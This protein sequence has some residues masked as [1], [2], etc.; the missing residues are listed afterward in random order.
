MTID[1]AFDFW[2]DAG[3]KDPDAYSPTLRHCHRLL[4][5]KRLP[6]GESLDLSDSTPGVY[7]HHRSG[8]GEFFLSRDSVM[9][10]FTKWPALK[11]ITDQFPEPE[12]HRYGIDF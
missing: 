5:S 2:T 10:T 12:D 8:L 11:P 3:G 9:Q 1:I 6:S 4:W 7:L